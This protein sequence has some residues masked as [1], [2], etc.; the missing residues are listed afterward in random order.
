MVQLAPTLAS[1][2]AINAAGE[3]IRR[4]VIIAVQAE[5]VA[6][7]PLQ[8]AADRGRITFIALFRIGVN[9]FTTHGREER[10]QR[11]IESR[12]LNPRRRRRYRCA[13]SYPKRPVPVDSVPKPTPRLV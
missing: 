12:G 4:V 5:A 13:A 3:R 2:V 8:A 6:D 10:P 7:F 11:N 1:S 9:T